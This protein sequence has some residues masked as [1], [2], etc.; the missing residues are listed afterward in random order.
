VLKIIG[1][2]DDFLGRYPS[3]LQA[4]IA[5]LLGCLADARYMEV[6]GRAILRL[7]DAN[8]KV[9]IPQLEF[10]LDVMEQFF[11]FSG[12]VQSTR[13]Q[14]SEGVAS[15]AQAVESSQYQ[16]TAL[17][18]IL[19]VLE[20]DFGTRSQQAS[21]LTGIPLREIAADTMR[22]LGNVANG[23]RMPEDTLIDLEIEE[24]VPLTFW[25]H[26]DGAV[27]Q[28]RIV[29]L[30]ERLTRTFPNDG[31][32]L[33]A[34]C[35]VMTAGFRELAPGP[36][37][38]V[39]EV[40]VNFIVAVPLGNPRLDVVMRSMSAFLSSS[41]S[42]R[43]TDETLVTRIL[44]HI[45]VIVQY[46]VE[47]AH[48]PELAY[49]LV[50]AMSILSTLHFELFA[51]LPLPVIAQLLSFSVK[52]IEAPEGL[53]KRSGARFFT[54]LL[55]F[56]PKSVQ[57]GE[58]MTRLIRSVLPD[59]VRALIRNIAGD[60]SRSQLEWLAEPYRRL[61]QRCPEWRSSTEQALYE[62]DFPSTRVDDA[63]KRR[64]VLQVARLRGDG[65]T[66]SIIKDFWLVCRGMPNGYG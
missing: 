15:V 27:T 43:M 16:M 35:N 5:V 29:G 20:G 4:A 58:T 53:A 66:H 8:R 36:F 51:R 23:F 55:K 56:R 64:F 62:S 31:Q 24:A 26:G 13:E 6:S 11:L 47:P 18:R 63:T 44:N 57:D 38:F 3:Y 10:L 45:W 19:Q 33:E 52:C 61:V 25:T 30:V 34:A 41:K 32:I 9:L 60:A 17:S 7:C 21:R 12:A 40:V 59:L 2:H 65:K 39:A 28:T 50:D 37:V 14:I 22:L 46:M 42:L 48:D 49:S 54:S 1:E